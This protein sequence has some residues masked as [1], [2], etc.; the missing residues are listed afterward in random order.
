MDYKKIIVQWLEFVQ[1]S[2]LERDISVNLAHDFITTITGPR[3]AG[4]TFLCFQTIKGLLGAGI[5]KSNILYI[6]FEDEKLLG[7]NVTDLDKLL[8]AFFELSEIQKDRSIYLFLDEI[9][10]ISQWDVWVRRMHDMNKGIKLILTGSSSKL[11][12]KEIS[13]RL[14]GRTINTEVFPLSFKEYLKWKKVSFNLKTISHSKDRFKVKKEFKEYLLGGGYPAILVNLGIEKETILQGYFQSMIFKD[15]IERNRIKEIKKI[16]ILANLIFDSVTKEISYNRLSNRLKDLGF[17]LSKNTVIEYLSYFE[18]AYLFFQ[19]LK[20]EYS[21][22]KQL[23]SIKKVYCID[24]GL[25]N[26]VSFKFS[27]DI[28]KLLENV[29]FIQ[30]KRDNY[31]VFY[32]RGINECDFILRKKNK[33]IEAIQVAKELNEDNKKRE[34]AGLLEAMKMHRLRKGLLLTEGLEDR[35][36]INGKIIEIKPV[37]KWLLQK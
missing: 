35:L 31:D 11:L 33:V 24:N 9:Q 28:G 37:W 25:L 2:V 20:F 21:L 36:K 23:G 22:A 17:K 19:N 16:K 12:S 26:A 10:N 27:E 5:P 18:D 34:I 1:P 32:H 29:V 13:T 30:L 8:D 15:I 6:N 14:R 7:A 4:K 3:R